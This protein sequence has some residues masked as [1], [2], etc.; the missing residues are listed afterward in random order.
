MVERSSRPRLSRCCRAVQTSSPTKPR[1][2]LIHYRD[3][4]LTGPHEDALPE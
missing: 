2:H 3:E 4:M 1:R